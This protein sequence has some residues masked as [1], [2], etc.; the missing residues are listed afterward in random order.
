MVVL[1]AKRGASRRERVLEGRV[2]SWENQA[3]RWKRRLPPSMTPGTRK[4]SASS[5]RT[6]AFR[7]VVRASLRKLARSAVSSGRAAAEG[8]PLSASCGCCLVCCRCWASSARRLRISAICAWKSAE[9]AGS[10]AVA[11]AAFGL[12]SVG[13]GLGFGATGAAGGRACFAVP[14]GVVAFGGR[15]ALVG[16]GFSGSLGCAGPGDTTSSGWKVTTGSRGMKLLHL[17]SA[18]AQTVSRWLRVPPPDPV[19]SFS[20]ARCRSSSLGMNR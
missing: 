12:A 17:L 8:C 18:L 2:V 1:A 19:S 4:N 15:G 14:V 9:G 16:E 11:A 10:V 5:L 7:I 20:L 6:S 13:A 3:P